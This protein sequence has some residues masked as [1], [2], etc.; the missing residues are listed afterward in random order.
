MADRWY[1][2]Q[3]AEARTPV[4]LALLLRQAHSYSGKVPQWRRIAVWLW[5]LPDERFGWEVERAMKSVPRGYCE[6]CGVGFAPFIDCASDAC[7]WIDD[8]KGNPS[9]DFTGSPI[10]L[11]AVSNI[12]GSA[13]EPTLSAVP[14]HTGKFGPSW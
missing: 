13:S 5:S 4:A 2:L 3:G 10:A 1:R 7:K 9:P 8:D 6:T 12:P 11:S 14:T